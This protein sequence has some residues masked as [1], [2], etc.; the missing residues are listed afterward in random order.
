[1]L[2][3][4]RRTDVQYEPSDRGE[5]LISAENIRYPVDMN[6][7]EKLVTKHPAFCW[8]D[9]MAGVSALETEHGYFVRVSGAK[10]NKMHQ[11]YPLLDDPPTKGGIL[12]LIRRAWKRPARTEYDLISENWLIWV[13]CDLIGHG[14]TE[15][16]ALGQALVNSPDPCEIFEDL[17]PDQLE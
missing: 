10:M 4:E 13:G 11:L 6:D 15:G 9:G 12:H 17:L 1:M 16:E 14:Q 3:G 5:P 8:L 7:L 2:N